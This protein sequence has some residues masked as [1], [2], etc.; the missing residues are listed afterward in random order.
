MPRRRS[1]TD[2]L[3]E[4]QQR[5]A[6]IQARQNIAEERAQALEAELADMGIDT[7]D[8]DDALAR[9]ATQIREAQRRRDQQIEK[10]KTILDRYDSNRA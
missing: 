5:L 7:E 4:L 9:L 2:S 6:Q 10:A 1:T 8:I 3:V